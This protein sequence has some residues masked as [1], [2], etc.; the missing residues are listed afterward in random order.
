MIIA[1]FVSF[2]AFLCAILASLGKMRNGLKVAFIILVLFSALRYNY[3]TDYM[4]YML[5]FRV[6]DKYTVKYILSYQGFKDKG[7]FIIQHYLH[8]L[9]WFFFVALISIYSNWIYYKFI[10]RYV[11]RNYYWLSL[12]IYVFTFDMF[13]LQQ[14][15]IRQALAIAM[16]LHSCMLLDRINVKK[17]KEII[18]LLLLIGLSISIHKSV[19]FVIPFLLIKFLPL[20]YGKFMAIGMIFIFFSLFLVKGLLESYLVEILALEE[21]ASFGSDY[22][23]E[24]GT[25]IGIRA[26]IEC[27]P[28]LVCGYYLSLEK[29]KDGPRFIVALSMVAPMVLPLTV[30]IHLISRV[31]FYFSIFY[32]V[33]IPIAYKEITNKVIRNGLIFILMGVSLY[34]YFDRHQ[35]IS[36]KK[37]FKEYHTILMVNK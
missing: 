29:T 16:V 10:K 37:Y 13:L 15:M 4:G 32:L 9:G 22:G 28:L 2:I 33:S 3:G 11:P 8:P 7:W 17:T 31:S 36:Y 1:L 19:A 18:L 34:V 24:E 12:Y 20:K 30:I 26:L 5:E 35:A 14:S 6:M 23:N 21:F 25:K 27:I